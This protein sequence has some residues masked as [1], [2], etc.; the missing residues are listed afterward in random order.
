M[1]KHDDA[2]RSS[3]GIDIGDA[4]E[5]VPVVETRLRLWPLA[6]DYDEARVSALRAAAEAFKADKKTKSTKSG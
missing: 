5:G 3:V 6:L 2:I 4:I 1:F